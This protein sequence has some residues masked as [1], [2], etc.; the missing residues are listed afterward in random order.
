[1]LRFDPITQQATL[2]GAELPGDLK[3]AGGVVAADGNMYAVPFD[4][5]QVLRFDPVRTQQAT[6]VGVRG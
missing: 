2:V 6:L 4:A 1:M 3:W 5:T